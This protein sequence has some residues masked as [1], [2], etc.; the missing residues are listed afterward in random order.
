MIKKL[1]ISNFRGIRSGE[2]DQ[3]GPLTILVG[4]NGQGKSTILEACHLLASA[5][6]VRAL[7]RVI[8]RRG[9]YGLASLDF[10]VPV[11]HNK[12]V[13]RQM[14]QFSVNGWIEGPDAAQNEIRAHGTINYTL[15]QSLA[16]AADKQGI[17]QDMAEI[18]LKLRGHRSGET[19]AMI[20]TDGRM[21]IPTIKGGT[22]PSVDSV[23][24]LDLESFSKPE[25]IRENV[26]TSTVGGWLEDA[27]RYI[28]QVV[29]GLKDLRLVE[30]HHQIIPML[31]FGSGKPSLPFHVAGD[32]VRR[33]IELALAALGGPPGLVLME[34]PEN[35]LHPGARR[36]CTD[37]LWAAI[38]RGEQIILS[39]HNLDLVD[40]VLGVGEDRDRD[41]E[42]VAVFH[43]TLVDGKLSARR[44]SGQ[45][46][47]ESRLVLGQDLRV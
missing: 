1:T 5:P 42:K 17:S 8:M 16:E 41:T 15:N 39:T 25:G 27:L 20:G 4:R 22:E 40:E 36:I 32:G 35:F 47:R 6:D 34:E 43:T 45:E 30:L 44:L 24:F 26:S 19:A 13:D 23:A 2:I 10:L 46:A 12:Q 9:W 14:P 18:S 11:H 28:K 37:L 31:Y 7:H 33:I 38:E 29:P 3:L 21:S